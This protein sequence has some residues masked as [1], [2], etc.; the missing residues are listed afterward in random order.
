[1]K[2]VLTIILSIAICTLI[3]INNAYSAKVNPKFTVIF[4]RNNEISCSEDQK[5]IVI[6]FTN[7]Y[8]TIYR[9]NTYNSKFSCNISLAYDKPNFTKIKNGELTTHVQVFENDSW[10]RALKSEKNICEYG[11]WSRLGLTTYESKKPGKDGRYRLKSD[12][13][14][15]FLYISPSI[16]DQFKAEG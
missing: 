14:L 1:M 4:E 6:D 2:R 7:Y 5:N 16:S 12:I 9:T 8:T 15:S 3:P 10:I 13:P 11:C